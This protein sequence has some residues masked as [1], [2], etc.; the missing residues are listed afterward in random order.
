MKIPQKGEIWFVDFSCDSIGSEFR[1]PHPSVCVGCKEISY[2]EGYIVVGDDQ[3]AMDQLGT[4]KQLRIVVPITSWKPYFEDCFYMIPIEN[5]GLDH[6]SAVNVYQIRCFDVSERFDPFIRK[7]GNL[8]HSKEME[9]ILAGIS[10]CLGYQ[11][12]N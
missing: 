7:I 11:S 12:T 1:N 2:L 5:Y 6:K 9:D 4:Q 10:Y 3:V 8:L